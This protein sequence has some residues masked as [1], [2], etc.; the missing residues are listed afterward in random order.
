[1]RVAFILFVLALAPSTVNAA[2]YQ[3]G[4]SST[5]I[6]PPQGTFLAGYGRDRKS[7]GVHDDLY[8]KAVFISDG[9]TSIALLTLDSIGLTRPDVLA[10]QSAAAELVPGLEAAHVVV[11]STHTHAAP[12][13]VGLWG[14]SIWSSG[15]DG[16]YMRALVEAGAR[17]V[18]AAHDAAQ[19]AQALVSSTSVP[20]PW[21]E[22]VSEP[23][24]LDSTLSVLQFVDGQGNSI[25]TLTN[26]ACHPTVLGPDNTWVSAD[27]LAQ[28]YRA[29]ASQLPG[30]HLFLQGAIGGWVQ[31]LQGDRSTTR[32][33]E[34]GDSLAQAALAQMKLAMPMEAKPLSFRHKTFDVPLENWGFRLVMWLG[35]L[36]RDT[37]DGAMRTSSAVFNIGDAYFATHPGETSPFYSFETRALFPNKTTFVLGL[38]Q[39]AMGY[40]LKTDYFSDDAVYPNA[41]YLRSVSVGPE[42]GPRLME[43]LRSL[44]R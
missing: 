30:E 1:M 33:A 29:M 39:D 41:E 40:I 14:E 8:A 42:A 44:S 12:D 35:V 23:G 9:S 16:P 19:S 21:V 18:L 32:A 15:R 25:A 5:V 37:Y 3:V 34:V 20:L 10:I 38:S 36:E 28:F 31:P 24:L 27:Y 26:Y 4:A 43:T 11:T 7:E 13:V 22:N 2:N 17:T 6:N